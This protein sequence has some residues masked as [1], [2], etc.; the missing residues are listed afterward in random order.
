MLGMAFVSCSPCGRSGK[1]ALTRGGVRRGVLREGEYRARARVGNSQRVSVVTKPQ[2]VSPGDAPKRKTRGTG[3]AAEVHTDGDA[4]HDE[5]HH[6]ALCAATA[7]FA[8]LNAVLVAI[9]LISGVASPIAVS[10]ALL[11]GYCFADFG[12]G[13]YHWSVDNYGSRSTPVFGYQIDAFQG[14][15][16]SPWTIT[17]RDTFNN[18]HR[19]CVPVLPVLVFMFAAGSVIPPSARAFLTLFLGAVVACQEIHKWAHMVA[20]PKLAVAFQNAGLLLSRREHGQ[21]H[22]SPFEGNYCIVSGWCNSFLDRFEFFRRLEVFF[23]RRVG[24]EP[25]A[26]QLDPAIKE[27]ALAKYAPAPRQ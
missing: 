10:L 8:G 25:I 24:T 21:H 2:V 15:H 19:A 20:P 27:A 16:K 1:D 9:A 11:A 23:F 22:N 6:V 12:T 14:H 17:E 5:P 7:A 13:V 18:L 26:W 3:R 4:L